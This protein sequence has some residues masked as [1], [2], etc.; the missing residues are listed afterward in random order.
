MPST[1]IILKNYEF[2]N[3]LM[4]TTNYVRDKMFKVQQISYDKNK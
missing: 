3:G 2:S 4:K 1:Y